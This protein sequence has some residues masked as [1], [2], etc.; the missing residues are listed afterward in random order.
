MKQTC[1]CT[2]ALLL[3]PLLT[4]V[5]AQELPPLDLS[6]VREQHQFIPMR[7]GTQLSA[8]MYFPPGSGPWPVLFEQRYADI[9][10]ESTRRAAARLAMG[11]Y[12]VAMVNYRGTWKSQGTWVGYRA[13]GW[14]EQRRW[15]RHLR[16]AWH[17][18][19]EHRQG[20]YLRKFSGGLRPELPRRH[21]ATPPRC[22]V[23]G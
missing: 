3:L 20:W 11:G 8:N 9:R 1:L 14:G 17:S 21:S 19:V 7:D 16:M 5:C 2:T 22:S 6:P 10:G 4:T 13:L 23:H 18:A 12:V 15:L